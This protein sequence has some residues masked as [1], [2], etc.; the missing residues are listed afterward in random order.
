MRIRM[1]MVMWLF[2]LLMMMGGVIICMC[3]LL[4]LIGRLIWLWVVGFGLS[5]VRSMRRM[6]GVSGPCRLILRLVGR[7]LI[8]GVVGS[9]SV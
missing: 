8:S 1:W 2:M 4:L 5:S 9:G 6:S 3:I 7:R